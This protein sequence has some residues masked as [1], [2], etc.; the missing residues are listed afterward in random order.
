[1][2]KVTVFYKDN[3]GPLCK[4]DIDMQQAW[5]TIPDVCGISIDGGFFV[6]ERADGSRSYINSEI[7]SKIRE[8]LDD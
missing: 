4:D 6:I 5:E 1:M 2:L 8:E 7:V 3:A